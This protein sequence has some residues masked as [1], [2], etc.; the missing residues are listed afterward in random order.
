MGVT[1]L[2]RGELMNNKERY[3][4]FCAKE[5][6]IPI[7]SQVWWLNAVAQDSWDVLLYETENEILA[8]MVYVFVNTDQGMKIGKA[9]LTQN[10]GIYIKY[11][12]ILKQANKG[13]YEQRAIDAI[14]DQLEGL[15]VYH[16]EQNYH[17]S[18][19]NWLPFYWRGYQQTTR[20]TYVIEDTSDL[21]NIEK[22]FTSAL[23]NHLKQAR[24]N[25]YVREDIP[26]EEFYNINE[27]TFIR[28][29]KKIPYTLEQVRRIDEIARLRNSCRSF[30]I[31]DKL[32]NIHG[33]AYYV[34]DANSVYYI[35][36][37]GN[38]DFRSSQPQSL[39][40]WEG[41]KLANQ[42][43]K[44][45]DFEGSMLKTVEPTFREYGGVQKPYFRIWKD[46]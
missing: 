43:H 41:I 40:I 18:F 4:E 16:Y 5:K 13:S 9:T 10:N 34:W 24:K 42:L 23:R 46:Y 11:P 3:R 25:L 7:F 8:S 29:G 37:G 31:Y 38:P 2:F 1:T 12:S 20:Y 14:I 6:A 27:M 36:S 15:S 19:T 28:Q 22:N 21:D 35:M 45:F 44:K 26:I 32:G 33:G 39:C 30:G 17:Y